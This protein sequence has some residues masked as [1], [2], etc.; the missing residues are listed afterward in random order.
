MEELGKI[1]MTPSLFLTSH[2]RHSLEKKSCYK[3]NGTLW[4][5]LLLPF[6]WI[7]GKRKSLI[8]VT[9][10]SAESKWLKM[11]RRCFLFYKM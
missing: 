4:S 10:E 1:Y 2:I 5:R 8:L 3:Y 9:K 6:L 7:C 11:F